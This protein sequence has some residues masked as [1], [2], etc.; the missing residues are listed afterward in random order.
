[1]TK[2][3]KEP[4]RITIVLPNDPIDFFKKVIMRACEHYDMDTMIIVGTK[5]DE[6][7]YDRERS[8]QGTPFAIDSMTRLLRQE[9]CIYLDDPAPEPDD[10]NEEAGA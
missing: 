9:C 7:L 2:P 6:F 1:M 5:G 10:D 3:K 8:S 4:A